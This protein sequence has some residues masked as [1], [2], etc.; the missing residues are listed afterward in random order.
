[1]A[2]LKRYAV[3]VA[4]R[5]KE[6]QHALARFAEVC[7]GDAT[8]EAAYVYGSFAQGRIGPES[9]LDLLV[10]RNTNLPQ[11]DRAD[12]LIA[13]AQGRIRLDIIVVTPQE[14]RQRLPTTTFGTTILES[15]RRIDA[16]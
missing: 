14:F 10:V 3:R 5:K 13:A 16:T 8:V 4:E 11:H 7:A 15:M 12:D 1:M 6:L 2:E 9:D